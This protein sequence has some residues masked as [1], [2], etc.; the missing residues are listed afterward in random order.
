MKNI[1]AFCGRG[2]GE[3]KE[4]LNGPPL[5][6]CDECIDDYSA[7]LHKGE[8]ELAHKMQDEIDHVVADSFRHMVANLDLGELH[9]KYQLLMKVKFKEG[10]D[11][12]KFQE[13]F[14][15]FKR[16][17]GQVIADDDYQTR[18]DLG[19]A[20]NE[21]GLKD[22]AFRELFASLRY[23]ILHRD[24]EKAEQI[25]S[26]I[27]FIGFEPKRTIDMLTGILKERG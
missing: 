25:L 12:P 2:I 21:M 10:P 26:V 14:D 7:R 27:L 15:E 8:T 20:Y 11:A 22:D 9:D 6:I 13:V 4:L 24:F 16:G 23:S 19:I 5:H 1:C 18:Y 17:V 3:V